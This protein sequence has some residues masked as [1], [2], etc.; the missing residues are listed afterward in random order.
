MNLKYCPECGSLDVIVSSS[1]S[2]RCK[3]CAFT[4]EPLLGSMDE[5]NAFRKKLQQ[6]QS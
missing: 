5:I 2:A 3:R 4:G 6:K 1:N